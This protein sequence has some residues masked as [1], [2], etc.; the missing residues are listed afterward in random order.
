[1]GPLP[2]AAW[3]A[4]ALGLAC[5]CAGERV[6]P[7]PSAPAHAAAPAPTACLERPSSAANDAETWPGVPDLAVPCA[8]RE[9]EPSAPAAAAPEPTPAP[10]A[11]PP[12]PAPARP[13]A[14]RGLRI[15]ATESFERITLEPR[16]DSPVIGLFRAGQSVAV[17]GDGPVT[18]PSIATCGQGWYAVEPRGYVCVGRASTLDLSDPR[19][20]AAADVLPDPAMAT[21]FHVDTSVGAPRYRRLPTPAEQRQ[22]ERGL[23]DYLARPPAPDDAAGGAIGAGPAAPRGAPALFAA[24]SHTPPPLLGLVEAYPGMRLAWAREVESGGRTFLVAPDFTMIPKD[25]VRQRPVPALQGL[26]VERGQQ[27][28]FPLAFLWTVDADKLRIEAGRA[29]PTGER[30]P[31]HAFVPVTGRVVRVRDGALRE[32]REGAYLRYE[33]ATVIEPARPRP[34]GVGPHDKWVAVR[35]TRGY[36]VAYEGDDPVYVT[37]ISPGADGLGPRGHVTP[38]GRYQV[39]AKALSWDMAGAE[40]GRPWKVDEVPRVAFFKD[41]YALHG[42][43]W[44][45]DF[46]RPKSHGCVNLPPDAARE[47]FDWLDPALPEG[48]YLVGAIPRL[49]HGTDVVIGP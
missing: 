40:R 16:W 21:G 15:A 9:P 12:A 29:V 2:R 49:V 33:L 47:L 43:W 17:R 1:M 34:R 8:P 41:N 31:R 32:T 36:L 20:L 45:D 48:W 23:D 30:W 19:V 22:A 38:P 35:I 37:P 3:T 25:K 18:G 11:P 44:H 10:S 14:A 7:Q 26:R 28:L 5:A 27:G 39:Y 46:G 42:T 13:E 4:L 6:A 24:L